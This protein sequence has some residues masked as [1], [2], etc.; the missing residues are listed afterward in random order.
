MGGTEEIKRKEFNADG[1]EIRT[2]V[3]SPPPSDV[4]AQNIVQQTDDGKEEVVQ[5]CLVKERLLNEKMCNELECPIC[6][7]QFTT[8]RV[9]P[10][11]HV[12]CEACLAQAAGSNS[13]VV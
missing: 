11:L 1:K 5:K 3:A 2:S 12:F 7:D 6:R 4:R 8:P 13:Y 10:C 9:L